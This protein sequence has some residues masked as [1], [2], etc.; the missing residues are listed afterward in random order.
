MTGPLELSA[1][2]DRPA[3]AIIGMACRLPGAASVEAFWTNLREGREAISRFTE[4]ELLASGVSRAAIEDPA[5]VPAGAI[6]E[7]IELFDAEFFEVGVREA[8]IMDPQHRLF[9][10]CAWEAVE[11]AGYDSTRCREAIGVFAGAGH[12]TYLH[13]NLMT[14]RELLDALDGFQVAIGSD[15]DYLATRVSYKLDLRG[16]SV[17]VQTASSTSLVAVH[18]ACRALQ[19]GDCD[20]ALA[21]G[22]SVKVPQRAGYKAGGVRSK[23]GHTRAFD[24]EAHGT[25]FGS[26]V[27]VV[28]LKPLDRAL[29]DGDHIH[30]VIRGS[31]VNNDGGDKRSYTAPS[32]QGIA[33][34]VEK[35][36]VD[37]GIQPDTIG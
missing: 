9:L 29:E 26:G 7:D 28:V 3:I 11:S 37:A 8:E 16:P 18:L 25:V 15:N 5:Y 24:A 6:L 17:T 32:P 1:A 34:V 4:A 19:S 21:G 20:V 22:V 13:N 31:A 2:A 35:A 10:E 14:H 36:I 33:A 12:N 30:A 23:D 27:G